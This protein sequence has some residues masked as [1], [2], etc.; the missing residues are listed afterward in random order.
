[1]IIKKKIIFS[2]HGLCTG[3]AE[4]FLVSLINNLDYSKFDCTVISYSK[5]NPLAIELNKEVELK[6]FSRNSIFDLRPLFET[7]KHFERSNPDLVFCIGFFSFFLIHIS[8]L[9]SF[10]KLDR[11][12]SY[13][14]TIHRNKKDHFMM[15]LYSKF[16]KKEDKI[17][18]VCN[19]QIDYTVKH[20]N[21]NRNFF[22]TV[23]N[24]VDTN[25]WRLPNSLDESSLIR[26]QFGIPHEAKVIIKVAGFRLEKNHKAAVDALNLLNEGGLKNVFL[27]FVGDGI[28]K[29][30][31]RDYVNIL[32]LSDKII[33]VGNQI[34]V[35]PYYWASDIFTL[36]SYGVETFSIAAL[37]AL[38][39]GL[40][41]V[42]TE[43]GGAN[44]M[45]EEGTNGYLTS[46]NIENIAEQWDK[47]LSSFFDK[48]TISLGVKNKFSLDLMLKSY[49]EILS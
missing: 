36:T 6:I 31:I 13:H 4:K 22:T 25:Y 40:P 1:M 43:I 10:R 7:R 24:G 20:Y 9:F 30:E 37:E 14:T 19:N 5:S 35:R 29:E 28:L 18:T 32:N 45:I 41:C 33:F 26:N 46:T 39:C 15:K 47:T 44:E 3:G 48:G 17:V 21:I 38:S 23:Y 49:E 42:L 34:D 11:I 27:L 8:T 16:I 12:I 2:I